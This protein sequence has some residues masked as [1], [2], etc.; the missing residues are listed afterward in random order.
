MSPDFR[1]PE[2]PL[3]TSFTAGEFA[4]RLVDATENL[5]V[6]FEHS[7]APG[8]VLPALYAGHAVLDDTK[9]DLL[10]VLG[11]MVE[12]GVDEVADHDIRASMQQ[13]LASL[14]PTQVEGFYSY[15]TGESVLRLGGLDAVPADLRAA[16]LQAVD[17]PQVLSLIHI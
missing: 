2:P 12:L 5:L 9:A 10:Y 4:D 17:S 6:A 8:F 13:I 1:I 3:A 16:V 7:T 11:L 15:R 14:D